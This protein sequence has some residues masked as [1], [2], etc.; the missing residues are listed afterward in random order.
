MTTESNDDDWPPA[1]EMEQL[2]REA[3]RAKIMN[4]LAIALALIALALSFA[5]LIGLW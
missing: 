5:L 1:D 2:R 3:R 4:W